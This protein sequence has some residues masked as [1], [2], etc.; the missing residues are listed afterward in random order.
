MFR[1]HTPGCSFVSVN[2]MH[3]VMN[4]IRYIVFKTQAM[5]IKTKMGG[6]RGVRFIHF[7]NLVF[8]IV[9]SLQENSAVLH[10]Y[11]KFPSLFM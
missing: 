8:V 5:E 10:A 3:V 7:Q 2:K 4:L 9:V 11:G 1:I 6:G